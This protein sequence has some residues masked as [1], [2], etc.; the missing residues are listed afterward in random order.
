M[1]RMLRVRFGLRAVGCL[2]TVLLFV[3]RSSAQTSARLQSC[4]DGDTC[5]FHGVRDTA[6]RVRLAGIDTPEMDGNCQPAARRAREALQRRLRSAS[7]LR[8]DSVDVG[9]YGRVIGRVYADTVDMSRWLRRRGLAVQYGNPTCVS[10]AERERD[11]S[12]RNLPYDP[13]G[14]D[15]DCGD[16]DSQPV[17]QRF[18]RA[19]G[20][21]EQDPHRLD[22]DDDGIACESLPGGGEER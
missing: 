1:R 15:R 10:P 7:R 4:Y 22:G 5:T 21:P 19:A 12:P 9:R 17:A 2:L 14:P 8:V 20:G 16:F 6:V 13:D 11:L 18:F 3:P